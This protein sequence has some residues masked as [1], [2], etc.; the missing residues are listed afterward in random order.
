LHFIFYAS[1]C[2]RHCTQVHDVLYL[3]LKLPPPPGCQMAATSKMQ[4]NTKTDTLA[5]LFSQTAHPLPKVR[6]C[7]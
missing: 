3:K 4:H 7:S 6:L 5:K 2:W 1:S